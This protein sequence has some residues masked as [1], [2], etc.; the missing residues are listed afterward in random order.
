MGAI[1]AYVCVSMMLFTIAKENITFPGYLK[2][3]KMLQ[4]KIVV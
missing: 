1:N 3:R 4:C 2:V